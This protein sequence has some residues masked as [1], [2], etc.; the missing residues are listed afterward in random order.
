VGGL[1]VVLALSVL[2]FHLGGFFV[3]F[4]SSRT[5]V[6]LFFMISGFYMSLILSEKYDPRKQMRLFYTNRLLRIFS[7]YYVAL[8]IATVAALI[9]FQK[10]GIGPIAALNYDGHTL[11]LWD[12]VS[13]STTMFTIFGQEIFFFAKIGDHGLYWAWTA[14]DPRLIAMDSVQ[15]AWSISLELMFYAIVPFLVRLKTGWLMLVCALSLS[16]RILVYVSGLDYDPWVYRA[17]PCELCLFI[18]GMLAYR[19]HPVVSRYFSPN[20]RSGLC[21]FL[22][23]G[24]VGL[25]PAVSV[26]K[27]AG[28]PVDIGV[29]FYYT[30]AIVALPCLFM[31]SRKSRFDSRLADYSYPVYL[32]HVPV[33]MLYD[34]FSPVNSSIS[35]QFMRLFVCIVASLAMAGITILAVERPVDRWRQL[36]VALAATR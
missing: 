24:F 21:L 1:R 17:F 28:I 25:R 6:E 2:V 32:L 16:L 5:S 9:I 13:L 20:V 14:Q 27:L 33:I 11:S 4:A 18:M 29:W 34:A 8:F 30:V 7:T 22:F 19:A 12:R 15:P 10:A 31:R 36:R 26:L 3:H 23:P 35:A